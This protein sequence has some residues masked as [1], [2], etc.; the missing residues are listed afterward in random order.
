MK[1]LIF[2][3]PEINDYYA[4]TLKCY[5]KIFYNYLCNFCYIKV[6]RKKVDLKSIDINEWVIVFQLHSVDCS[7][8]KN[9]ILI[10]TDPN[11]NTD[12][13]YYNNIK[14]II[15]YRYKN[16]INHKNLQFNKIVY[17][18]LLSNNL[19][20]KKKLTNVEKDIDILFYGRF[21]KH[22]RNI[23]KQ[24]LKNDDFK[25]KKIV[26]RE[27]IKDNELIDYIQRSKIVLVVFI[28]LEQSTLDTFRINLLINLKAFFIHEMIDFNL[29]PDKKLRKF[30]VF[31]NYNRI[32][33]K[34]F[35]YLNMSQTRRNDKSEKLYQYVKK[36]YTI[37][38][39][40]PKKLLNIEK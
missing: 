16:I 14:L 31:S 38:K 37:D 2:Y 15:S 40:F 19:Y 33:N 11:I 12:P 10:E 22:R 18:P 32:I 1:N 24:L 34:C 28:N 5:F 35:R 26:W 8:F 7:H 27:Y 20:E 6:I 3:F 21:T 29:L 9:I 23:Y 25:N 17:M 36:K 13:N 30:I 39:L 4:F